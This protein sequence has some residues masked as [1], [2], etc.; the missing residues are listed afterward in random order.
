MG[1]WKVENEKPLT[2]R[3]AKIAHVGGGDA[4]AAPASAWVR[5]ARRPWEGRGL[6]ARSLGSLVAIL[7]TWRLAAV[8][9]RVAR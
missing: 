9:A 3:P 6:A 2:A 5:P 4:L 1:E 8:A 7:V